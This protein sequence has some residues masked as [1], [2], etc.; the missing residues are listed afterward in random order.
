[1]PSLKFIIGGDASPFAQAMKAV[2]T[3]AGKAG[4]QT[5]Q[6]FKK[7]AAEIEKSR[8]AMLDMGGSAKFYDV[9][10]QKVNAQMFRLEQNTMSAK[11][12]SDALA[13]SRAK[14]ALS[15]GDEADRL[16][17][18]GV[19][20]GMS[21]TEF[22][23]SMLSGSQVTRT[24]NNAAAIEAKRAEI[25]AKKAR[26]ADLATVLTGSQVTRKGPM[27]DQ[28]RRLRAQMTGGNAAEMAAARKEIRAIVESRAAGG[29]GPTAMGRT[30]RAGS[31]GA[32]STMLV[33]AARDSLASLA[34]G[35][36]PL[37][38]FLQQAPQVAQAATMVKGGVNGMWL[39]FKNLLS[40]KIGA[41]GSI[42]GI[43]AGIIAGAI[44]AKFH[45]DKLIKDLSGVKMP[46]FEPDYIPKHLK[47]ANAIAEGWKAVGKAVREAKENFDSV[48]ATSARTSARTTT[49]FE[50]RKKMLALEKELAMGRAGSPSAQAGVSEKFRAKELALAEEQR[51]AEMKKAV[52]AN[53]GFYEE[54]KTMQNRANAINVPS[55]MQDQNSLSAIKAQLAAANEAAKEV[56]AARNSTGILGV[57]GRKAFQTYNKMTNSGVSTEDLVAAENAIL[58]KRTELRM[59]ERTATDR[60]AENDVKRAEK[61]R[62]SGKAQESASKFIT[63]AGE[64]DE[65]AAANSAE[66][67]NQAEAAALQ[68]RI[69]RENS[70]RS[71]SGGYSME[72]TSN[73][74]IGAFA[75][76]PQLGLLDVNKSMDAKL[77]QIVR[78]TAHGSNN[79]VTT[80]GGKRVK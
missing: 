35:A 68:S 75:A 49:E 48:A 4:S 7:A 61:A 28:L 59:Q 21:E 16:A 51:Q 67:K 72:L 13:Q 23:K 27:K 11:M 20:R 18:R 66:A 40:M 8:A 78:N 45:T 3:S 52:A 17:A 73:Q 43:F 70:R 6:E 80:I 38:V 58:A 64:I 54:S 14:V 74:K 37:T 42:A 76:G 36:N 24:T 31:L 69:D 56:E 22:D 32:S 29:I 55:Q 44:A 30:G 62:L 77:A 47:A 46:E 71:G 25:A 1:M 26:D 57:N 53:K 50:H 10:L 12:A 65:Q 2:E 41:F 19:P 15:M 9:A 60:M 63:G 79:N 39:A 33:S 5:M 34:S